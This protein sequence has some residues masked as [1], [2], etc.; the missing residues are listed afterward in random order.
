[1]EGSAGKGEGAT[2]TEQD[3]RQ[4]EHPGRQQEPSLATRRE[5]LEAACAGKPGRSADGTLGRVAGRG[6]HPAAR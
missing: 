5:S 2:E 1:M 4:S 6:P 3:G